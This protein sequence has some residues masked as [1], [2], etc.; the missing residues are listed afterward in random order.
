MENI[1]GMNWRGQPYNQRTGL[2]CSGVL[3]IGKNGVDYALR[4]AWSA[5]DSHIELAIEPSF[6]SLPVGRIPSTETSL[7]LPDGGHRE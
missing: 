4:T 6:E 1:G 7:E 2:N 3:R 5:S